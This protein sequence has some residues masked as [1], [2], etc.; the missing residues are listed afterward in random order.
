MR[1]GR[2]LLMKTKKPEKD[3]WGTPVEGLQYLIK[4][5]KVQAKGCLTLHSICE[6]ENDESLKENLEKVFLAHLLVAIRK[7]GVLLTNSE[8]AGPDLGEYLTNK[9]LNLYLEKFLSESKIKTSKNAEEFDSSNSLPR[10]VDQE[11]DLSSILENL[12]I[13][14]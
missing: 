8:R 5:L 9:H 12:D 11:L 7:L 4:L 10:K 13:Q 2:V 6:K 1:G 3:D 14:G